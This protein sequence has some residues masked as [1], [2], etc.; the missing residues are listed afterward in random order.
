MKKIIL[1]F[2]FIVTLLFSVSCNSGGYL[3][4]IEG[5]TDILKTSPKTGKRYNENDD[6]VIT[7]GVIT[8]IDIFVFLNDI[9]IEPSYEDNEYTYRMKMPACDSIIYITSDRYYGK[10]QLFLSDVFTELCNIEKKEDITKIKIEKSNNIMFDKIDDEKSTI[11]SLD[12]EFFYNILKK[13][14]KKVD[15]KEEFQNY[16]K[17]T[18]Y[19]GDNEYKFI[20]NENYI[21]LLSFSSNDSFEFV[22]KTVKVEIKYPLD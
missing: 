17:I 4:T 15:I 18:Y 22:D 10:T 3:L 9:M 14:I 1:L 20:M 5:Q 7:R 8:D 12:I 13:P 6:L 16:K 11:D 21:C 2:V 19:L